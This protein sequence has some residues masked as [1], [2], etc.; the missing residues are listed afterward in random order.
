MP[1][2]SPDGPLGDL[3]SERL[4]AFPRES[5][6]LARY[7]GPKGPWRD[8]KR[9]VLGTK[10]ATV[11]KGRMVDRKLLDASVYPL[12]QSELARPYLAQMWRDNGG[13]RTERVPW[14]RADLRLL[15]LHQPGYFSGVP[16]LNRPLAYV[17]L[18]AAYWSIAQR[19]TLD[20]T[21][22]P[23]S[24][25]ARGRMQ[26]TRTD[27]VGALKGT[28]NTMLGGIIRSLNLTEARRG[29]VDLH[30]THNRWLAPCLWGLIMDVLHAI[31]TEAVDRFGAH[32]W[33]NDGGI[34]PLDQAPLFVQWCEDRWGLRAEIDAES[35]RG[36]VR[37]W[38][39]YS[40]GHKRSRH[41]GG[42][43]TPIRA[44][45]EQSRDELA[46]MWAGICA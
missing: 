22:R 28:R 33:C 29:V 2:L 21:Y 19:T 44:L 36:S 10:S 13:K 8:E 45:R 4:E 15:E 5:V 24:F 16:V 20:A 23:G 35:A 40:V 34:L 38:Q 41:P 37:G 39:R 26:W 30:D 46:V 32:Y 6:D 11:M 18:R 42:S 12:T 3:V 31:A 9:I 17:D 14:M 43:T 27:E 25:A 1:R 7:L